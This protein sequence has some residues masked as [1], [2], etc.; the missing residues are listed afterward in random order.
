[1]RVRGRTIAR[2]GRGVGGPVATAGGGTADDPH[3]GWSAGGRGDRHR[4]LGG[5]RG[6]G[7]GGTLMSDRCPCGRNAYAAGL[8]DG[9]GSLS[10]VV[11][12]GKRDRPVTDTYVRIHNTDKAMLNWLLAS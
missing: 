5:D 10:I 6:A 7:G 9:E 2:R 8:F 3:A 12:H 4:Q 1:M 11:K